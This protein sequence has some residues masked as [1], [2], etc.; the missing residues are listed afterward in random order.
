MS[1]RA[2]F[3]LLAEYNEWM[4]TKVYAAAAGLAPQALLQDRGAFFGSI[5]GTLN[6]I[7]AGDTIWLRRFAMHPARFAALQPLLDLPAPASLTATHSTDLGQL[8]AHRQ[9]L[10]AVIRQW[11]AAL[12]D[13]DLDHV[14]HYANTKGVVSDKRFGSLVLHF[15]NHQ[16]HHR[17]QASTLLSQVGVNIGV[18][19]LLA[20]IPNQDPG[21]SAPM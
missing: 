7:V 10:D 4:N 11:T 20:L 17:G 18:T 21:C 19:D 13:A 5:A 14:L 12:T 3:A 1:E 6:H 16:T 15:F 8:L 2:H 9:M